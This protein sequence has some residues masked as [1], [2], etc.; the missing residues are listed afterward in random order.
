[1]SFVQS[2]VLTGGKARALCAV[3]LVTG[4]FWQ[5]GDARAQTPAVWE[6][7]AGASVCRVS[8]VQ[9][10]IAP[11]IQ[12]LQ[13]NQPCNG[14]FAGFIGWSSAQEGKQISFY[15][16]TGGQTTLA[17]RADRER[18]GSYVGQTIPGASFTMLMLKASTAAT[19]PT[20]ARPPAAAE[21]KPNPACRVMRDTGACAQA[22]DI[23]PP[24][25]P[26]GLPKKSSITPIVKLDI[27]FLPNPASQ[28]IGQADREV[29]IQVTECKD[30]FDG[31]VWCET[32]SGNFTGWVL[33]QDKNFVYARNGCG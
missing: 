17:A 21:V 30:S 28:P 10:P 22:S 33:K 8:F 3:A 13:V 20:P 15:G 1:M 5:G 26:P 23:G 29:C 14:I 6:L 4:L 25:F 11:G 27:R 9:G 2:L 12:R 32:T 19:P 16:L 24:R 7:K 18:P 31:T